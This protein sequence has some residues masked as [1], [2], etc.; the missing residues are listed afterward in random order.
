MAANAIHLMRIL[1]ERRASPGVV[2]LDGRSG[3]KTWQSIFADVA[4]I[5]GR[6]GD[7]GGQNWLIAEADA[8]WLAVGLLGVLHA[9]GTPVLPA[10]LEAG[11]LRDLA[12]SAAGILAA[13][14]ANIALLGAVP[15]RSSGDT[16]GQPSELPARDAADIV[17]CTSGST[18]EPLSIRKPVACLDAE[19][20]ELE[21]LFGVAIDASAKDQDGPPAVFG[22]V[23]P[24]H[25]YGLL[26]RVLW[27]LAAAR[28]FGAASVLYPEEVARR[29]GNGKLGVLV[30]SPAFLRRVQPVMEL[31]GLREHGT[32]IFSSGGPLAPDVAAAYNLALEAPVIEVYGSTETGGIAYRSVLD[33]GQPSPWTRFPAVGLDV[34]AETGILSVRSPY[35]A[36]KE[37]FR[38]ADRVRLLDS[39]RFELLGRTDRI[40]KIEERRISLTEIERRLASIDLVDRVRM[41]SLDTGGAGRQIIGAVVQPSADGWAVLAADGKRALIE[42]LSDALREHIVAVA[43][44]RRWRFVQAV[45]ED[46]RG[47]TTDAAIRRLFEPAAGRNVAPVVLSKSVTPEAL[48]LRLRF[49]ED[50]IFFDGHF[51]AAPILPGVAQLGFAVEFGAETLSIDAVPCRVEAL[52]FFNVLEKEKEATLELAYDAASAVL[53][54]RYYDGDTNFSTGRI[55]YRRNP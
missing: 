11:H 19:V 5:C 18:G 23:P 43:V 47:K 7:V 4:N 51:D 28:P 12:G 21:A 6:L 20:R 13:D 36:G 24:Y 45:P 44:P 26:F 2:A 29:A 38:T 37:P 3:E 14:K 42:R 8:Y 53:R 31:S 30:T 33:A 34:D 9:G 41:V 10:N 46:A 48:Q 25:I 17:L 49:P 16:V 27:P 55:V 22:T 32:R 52:K 50:L 40:A 1:N 35:I 54:F 15:L 39:D